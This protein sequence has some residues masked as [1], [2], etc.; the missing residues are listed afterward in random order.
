M[1]CLLGIR[2]HEATLS[3]RLSS[4]GPRLHEADRS[5]GQDQVRGLDTGVIATGYSALIIG[6]W[7]QFNVSPGDFHRETAKAI[8]RAHFRGFFPGSFM[9]G[10]AENSRGAVSGSAPDRPLCAKNGLQ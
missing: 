6:Q 2:P 4:V 9:R 1:V 10:T 7:Q 5:A 3:R 8:C